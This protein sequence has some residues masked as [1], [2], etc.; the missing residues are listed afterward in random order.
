M[1][2]IVIEYS[3]TLAHTA[4]EAL[5]NACRCVRD[6][7]LFDLQA[8]KGRSVAYTH[9]L[10]PEGARNFMHVTVSILEG[11]LEQERAALSK[12]IFAAV[13]ENAADIDRLSVD[14]REMTKGT[15]TK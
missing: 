14:I 7:G 12:H 5:E 10:L 9:T 4:R 11:R 15:Y 6:S 2:H 3:D 13:K 8:I 1:P